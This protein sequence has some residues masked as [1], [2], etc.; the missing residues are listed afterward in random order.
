MPQALNMSLFVEH[1]VTQRKSGQKLTGSRSH[2]FLVPARSWYGPPT[3]NQ[4]PLIHG[5]SYTPKAVCPIVV[6]RITTLL[7]F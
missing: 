4:V 3:E 1:K 7:A 2:H 5:I 6:K